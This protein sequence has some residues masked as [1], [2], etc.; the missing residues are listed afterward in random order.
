MTTYGVTP[1]GFVK[2]P[3][4]QIITDWKAKVLGSLASDLD[5]DPEQPPGQMIGIGGEALGELWE[6]LAVCFNATNRGDAEG[7]LLENIGMLTG[8]PRAG[9]RPS[10]VPCTLHFQAAGTYAAGALVAFVTGYPTARWTNVDQIIVPG[11]G[12]DGSAIGSS[13]QWTGLTTFLFKSLDEGPDTGNALI[14]AGA[15][16]LTQKVPVTGWVSIIDADSVSLGALVEE[17]PP[18]RQRQRDELGAFGNNTLETTRAAILRALTTA[19][20]PV[21]EAGVRMYENTTLVFDPVTGLPGKTYMAVVY[22]GTSPP[23]GNDALIAQ[24]IWNNKGGT[25]RSYGSTSVSVVDS[26]GT[27]RTVSF[28]RATHLDVTIAMDLYVDPGMTGGDRILLKGA[29]RDAIIAASQGS[30][31]KMFGTTVTPSSSSITTLQPGS[32]FVASAFKAIAQ[33]QTGVIDI[34]NFAVSSPTPE[35][36]GNV[37][38][39]IGFFA[40]VVTVNV[41][42]H[43]FVP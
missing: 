39:D 15:G 41:T 16:N 17:D 33:G 14:T 13:H 10:F 20:P 24:A 36:N 18:Y 29:I 30:P 28:T 42:D 26:Q 37:E 4:Q 1:Q 6:V 21:P 40:R 9:E 19:T 31:F 7:A 8:T 5:L 32:D 2:K 22:D 23:I 35:A 27:T 43:D 12:D 11:T 25:A 3:V 34:Q 38:V